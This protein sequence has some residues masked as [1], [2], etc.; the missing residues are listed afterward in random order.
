M[1]ALLPPSVE[2]SLINAT[3]YV[4][5][6]P[7][8]FDPPALLSADDP[9]EGSSTSRLRVRLS[10]RR[11]SMAGALAYEVSPRIQSTSATFSFDVGDL[12]RPSPRGYRIVDFDGRLY[13]S[14][15]DPLGS[16]ALHHNLDRA[17][18]TFES[19][20][21]DLWIGR[22]P[23][24]FGSA[25]TVSPTDVIV[26]FTY[27][28]LD[29]EERLGVDAIRLRRAIGSNSEIE[30]GYVFGKHLEL[31][32]SAAFIQG[33][34]S[35]GSIDLNPLVI[36]FR[37]NLLIGVDMARSIGEAGGWL[38]AAYTLVGAAGGGAGGEYL[39]LSSGIDRSFGAKVYGMVEYH[40]NGA[41]S[42]DAE[43]YFE[44]LGDTAYTDGAVYLL[45]RHY[46][47]PGLTYQLTPLTILSAQALTNLKDPSTLL[48]SRV[49][50]SLAENLFAEAGAF[51]TAGRH[52]DARR[53]RP[54]SE[55]GL[56]PRI[57]FGSMRYYF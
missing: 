7:V 49:E 37:E 38:E 29:K 3:G 18:I 15:G 47:T 35:A 17:L 26:P 6:F 14:K 23:L 8:A 51:I 30:I 16:F 27:E 41:G 22:Q 11:G 28:E 10:T 19:R 5:H 55:F 48:S 31:N 39:R 33:R 44:H 25:R 36:M 54:R 56:Y 50:Y 9:I 52:F 13:P 21:G 34:F 45:G 24:A 43:R 53:L 40:F 4:K 2:A 20:L 57:Y 12:P 46:I 1:V 32:R 42:A